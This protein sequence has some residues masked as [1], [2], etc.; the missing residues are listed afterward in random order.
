MTWERRGFW[1]LVALAAGVVVTAYICLVVVITKFLWDILC[2]LVR[3][4]GQAFGN[5]IDMVRYD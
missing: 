3:G 1:V 2:G 4:I 5:V